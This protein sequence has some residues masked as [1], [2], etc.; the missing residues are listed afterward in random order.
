MRKILFATERVNAGDYET[1]YFIGALVVF[2]ILAS[3]VVLSYGLNDPQRNQFKLFLHCI[4]IVTS[5]VPPELPMELSL[6]ITNNLSN[7]AKCLVYCTEPF[8]LPY[9]GKLDVLCFDKTGTLTQDKMYL[10]GVVPVTV[11]TQIPWS[12]LLSEKNNNLNMFFNSK[13]TNN[14]EDSSMVSEPTPATTAPPL[15]TAAMACCHSLVLKEADNIHSY[16]GKY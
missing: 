15:I 9:A 13:A 12:E 6:A 1:F 4:M 5:V 14:N 3:S 16:I 2:A 11:L 8:R 7:L 10:K